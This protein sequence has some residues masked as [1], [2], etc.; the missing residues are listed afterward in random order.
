MSLYGSIQFLCSNRKRTKKLCGEIIYKVH[1]KNI[2]KFAFVCSDD[3][4]CAGPLH[5]NWL[6]PPPPYCVWEGAGV[7]FK[8]CW[9]TCWTGSEKQCL[10][11]D[12]QLGFRQLYTQDISTHLNR[13]CSTDVSLREVVAFNGSITRHRLKTFNFCENFV[14]GLSRVLCGEEWAKQRGTVMAQL[15]RDD[16]QNILEDQSHQINLILKYSAWTHYSHAIPPSCVCMFEI[17]EKSSFEVTFMCD[18]TWFH[19]RIGL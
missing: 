8:A 19:N 7:L 11:K 2:C 18:E 3:N 17:R 13:R 1:A 10:H 14:M 12:S 9:N 6:P 4:N 5:N 15:L 16:Q